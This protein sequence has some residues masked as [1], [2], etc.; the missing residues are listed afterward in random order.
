MWNLH[1]SIASTAETICQNRVLYRF[2]DYWPLL[3]P[4]S[5]LYWNARGRSFLTRALRRILAPIALRILEIEDRSRPAFPH[6]YCVS[7]AVRRK[8]SAAGLPVEASPII[9]TGFDLE[10]FLEIEPV[11]RDEAD[12]LRRLLLIG[13]LVPEKGAQTA[14]RA[15]VRLDQQGEDFNLTI[16]GDGDRDFIEDMQWEVMR[17]NLG[18]R[19][20]MLGRIATEKIPSVMSEHGVVLVPSLWEDPLPRVALEAM[21]AA[22][23]VVASNVG[24]LPEIIDPET[25]GIVFKAGSSK[26]LAAALVELSRDPVKA[27]RLA[28]GARQ[29]AVE[30]FELQ[31]N[32][33]R[34]ERTLEAV[35]KSSSPMSAAA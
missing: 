5:Q 14:L 8:L 29:M 7:K 27:E 20:R 1:P 11:G 17:Q 32:L 25:T 10:S 9:H 33:D 13:R 2:A 24:G 15:L 23:I 30:S 19:V 16:V 28:N 35:A 31:A 34:I 21:A 26:D 12:S 22:R 4:Q 18:S 6:S 3:P